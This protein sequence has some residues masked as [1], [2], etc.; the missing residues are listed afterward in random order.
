MSLTLDTVVIIPKDNILN[1]YRSY[2]YNFTIAAVNASDIANKEYSGS[3]SDVVIAKS[4]GKGPD[5]ISASAATVAAKKRQADLYASDIEPT[6]KAISV[7]KSSVDSLPAL[8]TGFNK[9]S[10]GRFDFFI[11]SVEISTDMAF[12]SKGSVT[13]PA[14]L[15]FEIFEPYSINGFLEALH[16]AALATGF[17]SYAE[18][19]FI[20][21]MQFIGYPDNVALPEPKVIPKSTR[22]FMFKM[23]EIQIELT[24]KGTRYRCA[25]NPHNAMALGQPDILPEPVSLQGQTVQEALENFFKN[26]NEQK[27][28]ADKSGKAGSAAGNHDIYEIKFPDIVKGKETGSTNNISQS[29]IANP[30]R[31]NQLYAFLDPATSTK[32][33]AMQTGNSAA[34]STPADYVLKDTQI[35]FAEGRRISEAISAVVRDSNYTRDILR[36]VPGHTDDAGLINYFTI[37][38]ETYPLKKFDAVS[39]RPYK[40]YVFKVVPYKVHRT[41][42]PGYE[43]IPYKAETLNP[44]IWRNYNYLYTGDNIDVLNFKLNF[45]FAFQSEIPR[46]NANNDTPSATRGAASDSTVDVKRKGVNVE[47]L[48]TDQN[49]GGTVAT[50]PTAYSMGRVTDGTAGQ[51]SDDPYWVLARNMH[52]SIVNSTGGSLLIGELEIVGDPFFLVTGAFSNSIPEEERPGVTI[53]GEASHLTGLIVIGLEFRNPQDIGTFNEGG[54]LKFQDTERVPFGGIFKVSSVTSTF[55]E[56]QFRQILKIERLPGQL[57]NNTKTAPGDIADVTVTEPNKIDKPVADSTQAT[58]GSAAVDGTRSGA[59]SATT[60]PLDQPETIAPPAEISAKD[61]ANAVSLAANKIISPLSSL[62]NSITSS[63][64]NKF[65]K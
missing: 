37:I 58:A 49:S 8:L 65:G 35:Q 20:F 39:R 2:T 16:F 12:S 44:I 38:T 47:N 33:N 59:G 56:G 5:G 7:A 10:P 21:K 43:V 25:G 36:D 13:L 34:S 24:E 22:N 63:V 32:P 51:V 40:K 48:K 18:A 52:D 23:S 46:G 28:A 62:V 42:I 64:T 1:K 41:S 54:L 9:N 15:K 60:I 14:T 50:T 61:I 26:I 6:A 31:E 30:L 53:N 4:G 19:T 57:P 29:K 45:N 17:P 27:I 11:D 3:L 55:K